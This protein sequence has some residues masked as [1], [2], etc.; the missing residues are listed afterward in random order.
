MGRMQKSGPL[1]G[2]RTSLFQLVGGGLNHQYVVLVEHHAALDADHGNRRAIGAVGAVIERLVS[3]IEM[4]L[5]EAREH[6][7]ARSLER[8]VNACR[9][10]AT[11]A[12]RGDGD[13]V[14][15]GDVVE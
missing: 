8:H 3:R 2:A 11:E 10:P 12:V 7:V 6:I 14:V 13:M 5:G 1:W 9:Q 15:L 4:E